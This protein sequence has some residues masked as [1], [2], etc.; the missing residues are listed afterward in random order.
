MGNRDSVE[1]VCAPP[2]H[3]YR[4]LSLRIDQ[5]RSI[6][7]QIS[8]TTQFILTENELIRAAEDTEE[9]VVQ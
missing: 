2:C 5:E 6:I 4:R 8:F 3:I 9:K 7:L 1:D